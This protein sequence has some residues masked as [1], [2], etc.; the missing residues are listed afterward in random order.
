MPGAGRRQGH[1]RGRCRGWSA[2]ARTKNGLRTGSE[3]PNRADAALR[4]P[5]F[6]EACMRGRWLSGLGAVLGLCVAGASADEIRWRPVPLE[7]PA[8]AQAAP[9]YVPAVTLGKPVVVASSGSPSTFRD[10]DV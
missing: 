8:P 5:R 7:A 3:R 4:V 6:E 1:F 10:G 9:Q 2:G